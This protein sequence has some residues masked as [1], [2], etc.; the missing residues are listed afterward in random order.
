MKINMVKTGLMALAMAVSSAATAQDFSYSYIEGGFGKLDEGDAIFANGSFAVAPNWSIVGGLEIGS[1]DL[2]YGNDADTL[3]LEGGAQFNQQ[4][5]AGLSVHFGAKLLYAEYEYDTPRFCNGFFC[6]G[7][8]YSD[9]DIGVIGN[10]GVRFQVHPKI[11]LEGDVKVS[12]NDALADD[13]LGF[14]GA[15]RFYVAPNFSIAPGFAVD[16]EL[17]GPYVGLRFDL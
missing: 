4:L 16:T 10:A 12:S 13:G 15:A 1:Y 17:D 3:L 6:Y 5:D 8:T 2:G 11:Q 7:G 9:D 14:Q